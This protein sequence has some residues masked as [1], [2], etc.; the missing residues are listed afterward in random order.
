MPT[1]YHNTKVRV[2]GKTFD[3]K[4]EAERYLFLKE[5][6]KKGVIKDLE[7]QVPYVLI[8]KQEVNGKK[9]RE[10]TYIADFVYQRN[11][12]MIVED[13]KGYREGTAYSVF[14]IKQKLMA[15]KYKTNVREI[16]K[17]SEGIG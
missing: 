5:A 14:K 8:P 9:Y 11:G 10:C 3:S 1:K 15:M 6:E 13:V 17:A 4:I 7:L 12:E 16:T 2:F